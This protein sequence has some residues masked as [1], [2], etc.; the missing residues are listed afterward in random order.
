MAASLDQI[1]GATR[2]RLSKR[3]RAA[4]LRAWQRQAA[5]HEPRGFRRKLA[6]VAAT[7]VAVIAE[8]KKASPSKGLIREHFDPAGLARE[9]EEG[10][11][12]ALSVLT[13]PDFF[14]GSLENLHLASEN[15]ALPCLRKDF[16]VDEAQIVEARANHADAILLIV[17]ALEQADLVRLAAKARDTGLDVLCEA[18]DEEQLQRALDAG[19]DLVGVNSR[20]LRTFKVDLDTAFRL[21]KKFPR[22]VLAVA[23]SGIRSANDL[24]DLRSVGYE[25]FL[26]GESLMKAAFPGSALRRLLGACSMPTGE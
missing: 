18:H 11:A 16:I 17:A 12:A 19:C 10:G 14:Q 1:L 22:G 6:A 20:D 26:I 7:G 15:T 23:E 24:A 21:A 25:A 4:D 5:E 2:Q 3:R 8:L 13:E 9:L